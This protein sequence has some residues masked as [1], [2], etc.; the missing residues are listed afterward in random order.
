MRVLI[1]Y[2]IDIAKTHTAANRNIHDPFYWK[3]CWTVSDVSRRECAVDEDVW[4]TTKTVHDLYE[5]YNASHLREEE[6]NRQAAEYIVDK[7][8]ALARTRSIN[9]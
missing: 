5:I 6:R 8:M 2:R 9:K 1:H 7:E 4:N 3:F